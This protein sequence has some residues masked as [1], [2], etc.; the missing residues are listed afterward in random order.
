MDISKELIKELVHT[1]NV[2][3]INE[4][5]SICFP[6]MQRDNIVFEEYTG[7]A[8]RVFKDRNNDIRVMHPIEMTEI[9]ESAIGNAIAT[10][11]IFD[12]ADDVNRKAQLIS[13]KLLPMQSLANK[14]TVTNIQEPLRPMIGATI[15]VMDEE[16]DVNA[17]P[18]DIT[19]GIH[20]V[21]DIANNHA[22]RGEVKKVVDNYL[23]GEAPLTK[24]VRDDQIDIKKGMDAIEELN[25]EDIVTRDDYDEVEIGDTE[26]DDDD[27]VKQESVFTKKPKKLKPIPRDVVA[28]ITVEMNDIKDANDQAM[29]SGYTCSKLE[30]VDFYINV[31]D[32]QDAR[33]IVPHDRNYLV[34]MQNDLNRLLAQ[35][36]RLKPIDYNKRIWKANVT[37]PERG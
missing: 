26:T 35:I 37:L 6:G 15:G 19:N 25:P 13:M 12:D 10:G 29:L 20:L 3:A 7:T 28:Y 5:V 11:T 24:E 4:Y 2:D 36:L 16:G 32:T 9:Q 23:G 31:I 33:Y 22:N 30:L 17:D 21:E 27:N 14:G 34:N 1:R 8:V 18:T